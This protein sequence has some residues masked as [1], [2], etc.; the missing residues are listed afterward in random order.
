MSNY[1]RPRL[2]GQT[3][4]FTVALADRRSNLLVSEIELLREAV[5]ATLRERPIT[6]NAFV[7]LPDHLHTVWTL[8]DGDRDYPTRWRLIKS[9]FSMELPKGRSRSSHEKRHE[10][11]LW[12][13]RFWEHH[14]RDQDDFAA[15]L[16]YCWY[17]P[18]KHGLVSEPQDWPYSSYLRDTR[19]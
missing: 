13:R 11:G 2:A 19:E 12:Q 14:V 17:N 4:F 15:H 9:R 1:R 7:V 6:I 10:R 3:I 16:S 5:R 8:P 18:V